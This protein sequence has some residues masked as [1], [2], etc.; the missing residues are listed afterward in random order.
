MVHTELITAE[1]LQISIDRLLAAVGNKD[2]L[3]NNKFATVSNNIVEEA[4][5]HC[6]GS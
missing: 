1:H 3:A 6:A 2:H 5:K 4:A